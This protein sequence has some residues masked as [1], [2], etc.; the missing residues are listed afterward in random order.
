MLE[1]SL[2]VLTDSNIDQ[3]RVVWIKN[4]IFPVLLKL[5]EESGKH[6]VPEIFTL[7]VEV[8]YFYF[9]IFTCTGEQVNVKK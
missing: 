4:G 1:R 2:T 7:A 5:F 9:I 8:C 3:E 6:N